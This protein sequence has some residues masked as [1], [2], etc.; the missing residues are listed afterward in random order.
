MG[1]AQT[2]AGIARVIAP[3]VATSAYQ[4]FGP[5]TPFYIAGGIVALV[6]VLA[7]RVVAP[8]VAQPTPAEGMAPSGSGAA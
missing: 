5:P 4:R 6:G 1:V 3:L 7:F 8:T 2:F